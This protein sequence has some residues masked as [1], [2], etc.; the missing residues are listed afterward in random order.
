MVILR[1]KL[2]FLRKITFFYV[3]LI[4]LRK[5][6]FFYVKLRKFTSIYQGNFT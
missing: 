6:T 5:I 3:K 2:L 4:F 1:K